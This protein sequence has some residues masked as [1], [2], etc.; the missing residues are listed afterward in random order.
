VLDLISNGRVDF[1]TGRSSTRLELEGFGIHPDE[2]REMWREALDHIVDCWTNEY[3]EFEGKHWSLPRRRVQPKPIQDPHPPIFAATASDEGHRMM[4]EL[5]LGLC[6]FAVGAPPEDVAR[7]IE[8][9]RKAVKTCT[10]PIAS[11]VNDQAAAFT[12]VNCAPTAAE[13]RAISEESFLWYVKTS[14]GLIGTVKTWLDEMNQDLG[15]YDYLAPVQE[16]VESKAIDLLDYNFLEDSKA[17][18]CGTP[19][20]VLETAKEYEKAG[21][22]LLLCLINPFKIPHEKVMQTIELMGKY[23]LPEFRRG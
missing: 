2:T 22:D 21:V 1:G 20:Q 15:T 13:S 3:S 14:V 9:Y 8:I 18:L 10:K 16:A 17:V 5:G 19:D 4:G 23:V 6:S 7:R 12:M 11:F